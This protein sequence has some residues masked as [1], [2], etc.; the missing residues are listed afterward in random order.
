MALSPILAGCGG[1][2]QEEYDRALSAFDALP[3]EAKAYACADDWYA[4]QLGVE[5][6]VIIERCA[7]G[8]SADPASSTALSDQFERDD[9]N[10]SAD[11]Y[12][13]NPPDSGLLSGADPAVLC[14]RSQDE[15]RADIETW[16]EGTSFP[17]WD[18]VEYVPSV[19][20]EAAMLLIW[21]DVACPVL[22]E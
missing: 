6:F 15:I 3:D 2:T 11:Y 9:R 21:Q 17:V 1:P 16:R 18:G 20:H 13:A 14:A 8:T 5:G 7:E 10:Y 19:E 4:V 12:A 22:D